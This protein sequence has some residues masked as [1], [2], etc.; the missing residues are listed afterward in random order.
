MA[1]RA[2][3]A[4]IF[5]LA[6]ASLAHADGSRANPDGGFRLGPFVELSAGPLIGI[7]RPLKGCSVGALLGLELEP[8]ELGLRADAAY[9]FSLASGAMRLDTM[10]GLGSSLR[11]TVG[12][13]LPLGALSLPDPAGLGA[14]VAVKAAPWPDRFGLGA[15]IADLPW[16]ALRARLGVDAELVYTAYRLETASPLSGAA[17]FAASVEA[18]LA[19]RLRWDDRTSRHQ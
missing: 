4:S 12:G 9:D 13:L 19:L 5:I 16:R 1:P 18:R 15:T 7:D 3:L 11:A 6:V 8:F 14:R 17:A 2:L 10:I